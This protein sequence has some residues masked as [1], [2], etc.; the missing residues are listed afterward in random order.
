MD[1]VIVPHAS[2]SYDEAFALR[3]RILLA[4][5]EKSLSE[6]EYLAEKDH[7]HF[8]LKAKNVV[9]ACFVL[10][11]EK[12]KIRLRQM[13]VEP[14]FQGKGLGIILLNAAEDY[15]RKNH[16]KSIYCHARKVAKGFYEKSKWTIDGKEFEKEGVLH[17]IMTK[18]IL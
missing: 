6:K 7:I 5:L 1:V 18:K 8:V 10:V 13:V 12:P 11:P 2:S 16:Y 14:H 9:I 15:A 17:L 4:P 3:N